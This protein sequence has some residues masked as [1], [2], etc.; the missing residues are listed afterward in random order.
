MPGG[1]P[2]IQARAVPALLLPVQRRTARD[3]RANQEP[4]SRSASPEEV[5]RCHHET[6]VRSSTARLRE[7]CFYRIKF[8]LL[9]SLYQ[10]S[11][12]FN[13]YN[14]DNNHNNYND[15]NIGSH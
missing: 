3:S 1:V 11:M 9:V 15:T 6:R 7:F 5:F 4:P 2:R 8:T 12:I 14:K 10:L 13:D